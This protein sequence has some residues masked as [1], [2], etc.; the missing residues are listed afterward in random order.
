MR[1]LRLVLPALA[2]VVAG[3]WAVQATACDKAKTT[4]AS[5]AASKAEMCTPE[6]AAACTPEMAAA[7]MAAKGKKGVKGA[8][9]AAFTAN[10]SCASKGAK[11]TAVNASMSS[12]SCASKTTATTAAFDHC[13]SAKT[14]KVTA[15][16]A[17]SG[18]TKVAGAYDHC[19]TTKSSKV[20]AV[21][22]GAGS[23]CGT[24]KTKTS[25]SAAGSAC[26]GHGMANVAAK[27][28]HGDCD[29]CSDMALCYEELESVNA[30]TQMVPLKNG[31]MFVYTAEKPGNVNA[32]QSAMSRRNERMT[33]IVSA[34]DKASLCPECKTLR[35]AM[36]SG[37][38]NREVVNIEGGAL[39]LMTSTDPAVVAKI[40]ALVEAHKNGR[41][42]I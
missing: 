10:A 29:A 23:A 16:A 38:M 12:G 36:A 22:A 30:R 24:S 31:V 3:T 28:G 9:T 32:V 13:A 17:S 21:A 34:G 39:T 8:R 41:S 7:C 37:K 25:A 4:N 19:A 15:V 11:T 40:H 18:G 1:H 26:T 14:S 35:G 27:A 20:S 42:K 5:A 33:Q 2:F 6:M